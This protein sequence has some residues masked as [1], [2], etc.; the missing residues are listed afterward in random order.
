MTLGQ[1]QA[2]GETVL[3]RELPLPLLPLALALGAASIVLY[4]AAGYSRAVLVVWLAALVLL[5]VFF[6]GRTAR[7]PRVMWQ[8]VVAPG[9]I[10]LALAPLYLVKLYDWPVQVGSDEIS[11]M[12][13]A[14]RYAADWGA[15]PFGL[16]YYLGHPTL[17][18][19]VWGTIG[20]AF[21]GI[22]LTTMRA[23]HA[24][25][26]LLAVAA[27]YAL[28]RQLLPRRWAVVATA[29][30]GLNHSLL[31]LSR[32]AMRENT[33]VLVE[34]IALALLV[35]GLKHSAP[36]HTF[37]GG[38]VAG[39]GFYVYFPARA[40]ILVWLL[41]LA[42]LALWFRAT[43]PL[44][45]LGRLAATALAGFALVAGPVVVAGF[46]AS[47]EQN[48]QQR[49]ALFVFSEARDLQKTWVFA[50]SV[51]DG[52]VKNVR[53]GLTAFNNAVEDHAWNYPNP[54]HGFVDPLSGVL[55]WIGVGVVAVGLVRSRGSPWPLLPL[56]GFL[57][58]WLALAFLVNKAPNYPRLLIALPFVAYLAAEA[59][60]WLAGLVVRAYR[61][62]ET[63]GSRLVPLVVAGMLVAGIAAWNVAIASD[64]VDRGRAAG[65]DIGS[66]GRYIESR[67]D[68]PG[69]TFHLAAGDTWPYYVWGSPQMWL[70][71]MRLFAHG[72]QVGEI[73]EPERSAA[74]AAPEPFVLFMS[75]ELWARA[76]PDL[77][78]RYPDGRPESVVPDGSLVAFDVPTPPGRSR[79]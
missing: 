59:L 31:M 49:Q 57:A 61:R 23:L 6:A 43:F 39:L 45:R 75:R 1:P 71:R 28:F 44:A 62:V 34:V 5:G 36:L 9:V 73:V 74:F 56:V 47:P 78:R 54:G 58:L 42:V 18:F 66:T 65:D 8:D 68:Q 76:G 21:G 10:V 77:Q 11:I 26:G 27:S 3:R 17:L 24:A 46:K 37:L 40:V 50:S 70:E 72:G 32:M 55:L 29:V 25:T 79:P 16:S 69:I 7:L 38:V 52:Y 12:T 30:L 14:Q 63:R 53:Y 4:G 51:G 20:D 22:D 41:F 15:D 35:R 19:L 33:V 13:A 60:R 64:F 48:S 67:R 2:S